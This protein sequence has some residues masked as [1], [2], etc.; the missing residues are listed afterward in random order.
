MSYK[1]R[2]LAFE[3]CVVVGVPVRC[4]FAFGVFFIGVQAVEWLLFCVPVGVTVLDSE[5]LG[6][7]ALDPDALG[8]EALDPEALGVEALGPEAL[9]VEAL[10][11]G[12]EAL[13]PETL[14]VEVLNPEVLD[15]EALDPEE[16]NTE[17]PL[18]VDAE[19]LEEMSTMKCDS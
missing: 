6:V 7:E 5:A 14:G 10:D 18:G 4:F 13:D 19:A 8:V 9:G 11:P 17:A 15:P 16:L 3:L 1:R 12:V 2:F